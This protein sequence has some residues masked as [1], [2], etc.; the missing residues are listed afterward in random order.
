MKKNLLVVFVLMISVITLTA[1]RRADLVVSIP[2]YYW[3]QSVVEEFQDLHGVRVQMVPFPDNET[4]LQMVQG[5][6]RF[7]II[8]PSD[9]AIEELAAGG[10]IIPIDWTLIDTVTPNDFSTELQEN[11]E[12]L[13]LAGFNLLNY[14]VPYFWGSLGI[15]YNNTIPGM[16]DRVRSEGFKVIGDSNLRTV[17][18]NSPRC[19]MMAG[20][21]SLPTP[22]RLENATEQD[23]VAAANLLSAWARQSNTHLI[24]DEILTDM[25]HADG[26]TPFDAVIAY[27]GDATWITYEN[28]NYSFY[29]PSQTNIFIDALTI[30]PH[31]NSE[32]AHMFIAHMLSFDSTE[33][34]TE[35]IFYTPPR[36]DVF[37]LFSEYLTLG[38][39]N[40]SLEAFVPPRPADI[41]PQ[42]FRYNSQLAAWISREWLRV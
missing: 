2:N 40:R 42:F 34:N 25:P 12:Y 16:S 32:L 21:L 31:A 5:G 7:D 20:L 6:S 15:I 27:S 10:Y 35:A 23:I 39:H 36:A 41:D 30:T 13:K 1:C 29:A 19:A 38:G 14:A 11:L 22:V 28:P 26:R 9:Y 17:I 18:Y 33:A 24:S 4:M 37:T 3:D 8:V